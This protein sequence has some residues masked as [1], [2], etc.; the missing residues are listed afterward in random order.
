MLQIKVLV[1][2]ITLLQGLINLEETLD[3]TRTL[4]KSYRVWKDIE[5]IPKLYFRFE[6]INVREW[7]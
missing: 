4:D 7:L 1:F 6:L 3:I 2:L 5:Y